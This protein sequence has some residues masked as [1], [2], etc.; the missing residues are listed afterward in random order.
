L[1]I[2]LEKGAKYFAFINPCECFSNEHYASPWM[3]SENG[4]FVY[5]FNEDHSSNDY[6][7]Y[8]SVSD[9]CLGVAPSDEQ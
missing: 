9:N 2:L 1:P 5:L 8:F 4:A 6:D 7:C 3:P